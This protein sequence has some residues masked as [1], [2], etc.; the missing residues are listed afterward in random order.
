VIYIGH[1][2]SFK[3]VT[4]RRLRWTELVAKF[5]DSRSLYIRTEILDKFQCIWNISFLSL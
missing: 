1:V 5:L 3:I 2:D 4:S